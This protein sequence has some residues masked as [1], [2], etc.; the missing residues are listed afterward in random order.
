MFA[1][2]LPEDV[3]AAGHPLRRIRDLSRDRLAP[4]VPLFAA[5]ASTFKIAPDRGLLCVLLMALYGIKSEAAFCDQLSANGT[6]RWFLGMSQDEPGLDPTVLAQIH[7]RLSRN[8]AAGEFFE[9]VL[10]EATLA[11]LLAD[12][13]FSLDKR[14]I[15]TWTRPSA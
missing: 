12:P 15:E 10:R 13:T 14:Q 7:T 6:F 9:Q 5:M 8:L 1:M 4:M 2:T 11:G 3:L